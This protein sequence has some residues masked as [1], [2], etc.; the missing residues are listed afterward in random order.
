MGQFTRGRMPEPHVIAGLVKEKLRRADTRSP[1]VID[2]FP[3]TW[4]QYRALSPDQRAEPRGTIFVWVEVDPRLAIRRLEWRRVCRECGRPMPLAKASVN[5]LDCGGVIYRRPD[6]SS[7]DARSRI[8]AHAAHLADLQQRLAK[9]QAVC[10][11]DGALP[12]VKNIARIVTFAAGAPQGPGYHR[13]DLECEAGN[14]KRIGVH[15]RGKGPECGVDHPGL[16]PVRYGRAGQDT[17]S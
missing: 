6:D 5:C 1:A 15:S 4:S 7:D 16:L 12:P 13:P 11:I 9:V 3:R 8:R 17:Y 14:D 10:G 2:G